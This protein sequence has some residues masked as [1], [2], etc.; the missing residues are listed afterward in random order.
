MGDKNFHTELTKYLRAAIQKVDGVWYYGGRGY[1]REGQA[2][3]AAICAFR[4]AWN[5]DQ[6]TRHNWGSIHAKQQS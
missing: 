1:R 4:K 5:A 6:V 3:K 2:N